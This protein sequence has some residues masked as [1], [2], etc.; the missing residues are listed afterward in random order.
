MEDV[1]NGPSQ[2]A[3]SIDRVGVRDLTLPLVVRD[4]ASKSQHTMAKVTLSVDLPAHFKGTHMSRFIEAL[5]D[6]SEELDYKSFFNLLNDILKR[7]EAKSAH[8]KLCFPYCLKKTSP[9]SGRKG[10]MSYDCSVE[11]ELI[12]GHLE[13]TLGVKVPVMTVCPCSK[14]ISDEG[15]HSQRAVIHIK[16]RSKGFV[17]IED[18]IEIAEASGSSQV[19]SLL[20]REDEKYV[21]EDSF[22]NPTFVEDVVRNV[23]KGLEKQPKVIWYKVDV[24]SF[25]SIHNHCAF[26]S[27]EKK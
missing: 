11:G 3:M 5:E 6:W 9:V 25:E 21:T 27:I 20:K 26:A 7:L 19:Y 16:T 2:V 13:F 1:Q 24:E 10:F 4:R 14:A 23:A 22:A 8:A 17:W 12:G 18:L 15:A